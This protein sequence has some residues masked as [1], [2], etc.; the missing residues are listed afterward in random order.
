MES[1]QTI[2]VVDDDPEVID[3]IV[4][5]LTGDGYRIET[6]SRWTEALDRIQSASPDAILLDLHLPTVRGETLLEFIQ[7]MDK[8]LP[9]IIVSSEITP[10]EVERLGQLGASGFVRKPLDAYEL[11]MVLEQVLSSFNRSEPET[12]DDP[13]PDEESPD[14]SSL[15]P[16][17]SPGSGATEI[18][19]LQSQGAAEMLSQPPARKRRSRKPKNRFRAPRL[20]HLRNYFLILVFS[21]LIALAIWTL[22]ERFS[23]G[24]LFGI[25]GSQGLQTEP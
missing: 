16:D 15:V 12:V 1:T 10:E 11:T 22:K 4:D 21:I 7:E 19:Q 20:K 25:S 9:V 17:I 13:V 5:N 2:L 14:P 8:D 6:A 18:Q 3:T 24:Y 23:G